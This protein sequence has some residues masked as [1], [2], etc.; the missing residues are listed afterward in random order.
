MARNYQTAGP[1]E[2]QRR[3]EY[4]RDEA[5]IRAFL[6]RIEI[7]HL[8]HLAGGQPYVTPTNFWFD[9]QNERI[10]FHSNIAGRLR[11]NLEAA[12]RVA[13]ECIEHGRFLPA[14]TA[15]EFGV[16]YRSA[17]VFGM[18]EILN[19]S[20]EQRR[21]LYALIGKYFP[22]MA[23]GKEYRPINDKELARTTVYAL[24]IESWTGKE[25]WHEKADVSPDWPPLP[26][27]F[28]R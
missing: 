28:E 5:W 4:V 18:V 23:P 9:E 16:Q 13:F 22:R 26:D 2:F 14:N 7:G 25:N 17:M 3:P 19:D 20:E 10:I 8:A 1:T 6:H 11:S 21:V 12:P 15:L 24:N 27:D